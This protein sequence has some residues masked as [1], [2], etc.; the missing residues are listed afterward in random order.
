MHLR[1]YFS[2]QETTSGLWNDKFLEMVIKYRFYASMGGGYIN[3]PCMQHCVF[4]QNA[5]KIS[6]GGVRIALNHLFI[7]H[8]RYKIEEKI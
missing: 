5:S 4:L 6:Y 2:Q 1:R 8:A 3:L 7:V